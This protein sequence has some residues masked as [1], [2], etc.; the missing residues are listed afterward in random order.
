MELSETE[1]KAITE[2]RSVGI[3]V[4]I[5]DVQLL[6]MVRAMKPFEK[7]EIVR[8]RQGRADTYLVTRTNRTLIGPDQ[9][10]IST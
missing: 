3:E 2:L 7:A 4:T 10:E 5:Y 6:M 1:I 8:D 9:T